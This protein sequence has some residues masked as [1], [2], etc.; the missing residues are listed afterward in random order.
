MNGTTQ[1]P[2]GTQVLASNPGPSWHVIK[3]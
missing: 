3:A 1:I 2:G